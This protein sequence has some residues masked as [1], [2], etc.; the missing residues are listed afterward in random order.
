MPKKHL[1][2]IVAVVLFTLLLSGCKMP[3]STAP[4]DIVG[5]TKTT[6]IRI[7][8]D[9]PEAATDTD[10][11]SPEATATLG[12][13]FSPTATSTPE[14]TSTIY[15]PT[16][17]KPTEYTVKEGEYLYCI[18]RRFDVNPEDLL[19]LN[20]LGEGLISP[21]TLLLIPQT[22][23]WP[24]SRVLAPH[25][26]THTVEEGD[27]VYSIACEYGDVTPEAIIAVNQLEEPY[28][29]TPGQTLDIP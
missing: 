29:L 27:T 1:T 28:D 26:T 3:A 19:S 17:T 14:P 18:A 25:P 22:G 10:V 8:T 21:G 2:V 24:G 23:S 6:P 9:S 7:Q 13:G 15:I 4:T 5:E 20:E 11:A 12:A 16:L